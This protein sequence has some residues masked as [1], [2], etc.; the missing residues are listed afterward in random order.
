LQHSAAPQAIDQ[1]K[2]FG[3]SVR[4]FFELGT[5]DAA[6]SALQGLVRSVAH[7]AHVARFPEPGPVHLNARARKPLEPVQ[8]NDAASVALR[9][10]VDELLARGPTRAAGATLRGDFSRLSQACASTARG[11]IMVGPHQPSQAAPALTRLAELSGFPLLCEATSQLRWSRDSSPGARLIDGFDWLLGCERLRSAL[12]PELILSFG[13]TP[14]SGRY[15]KLLSGGFPGQRFVIAAHGFPDPHGLASELVS[16]S[17]SD[18]AQAVVEY[19]EQK[20]A[21]DRAGRDRFGQAWSDANRRVWQEVERELDRPSPTLQEPAAVRAVLDHLPS[22]C[23]LVLGNSLPIREVDAYVPSSVRTLRVLSQRGANG[24][25]GLISGA[26]GAASKTTEPT[27]LLL[28]DVSFMHDL[29]G[30]AAARASLGPFA[31]VVL[32]NGGGRIFEQLPIFSQLRDNAE[33]ARFWL[34]PPAVELSH[35]AQLFGYR[36]LHV[37]RGSEIADA[38]RHATSELGVCVVHV[39]VEGSSAR[40]AEQRVRSALER[41][42]EPEP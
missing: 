6:P 10:S 1:I 38:I 23:T 37:P 18:A 22:P 19:L 21:T 2:L 31:I 34:T 29:A 16:A 5:P 36:Y 14:T 9:A 40:E 39:V 12:R 42:T 11:V 26:A 17:S 41:A 8:A 24:I 35:A 13:Q 15:E 25:D 27:V 28:G 7:A 30:L 4:A 33:A 3:E 32:D 20:G